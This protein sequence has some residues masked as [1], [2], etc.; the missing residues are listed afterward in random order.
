MEGVGVGG[1][2][3]WRKHTVEF[4]NCARA[5]PGMLECLVSVKSN[6]R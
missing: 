3:G 2:G 5:G 1:G 6:G 4:D